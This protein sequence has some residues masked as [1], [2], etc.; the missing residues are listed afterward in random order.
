[1]PDQDAAVAEQFLDE[2]RPLHE[3]MSSPTLRIPEI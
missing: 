3:T 2:I 1:V